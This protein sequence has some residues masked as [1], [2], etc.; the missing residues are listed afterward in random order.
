VERKILH[1]REFPKPRI[2]ITYDTT[3]SIKVRVHL[4]LEGGLIHVAGTDSN[5]ESNG[6]LLGMS[7]DV[8]PNRDGRIDTTTLLKESANSTARALGS[9]EDNINVLGGDDVGVVLEH[10]RETMGEVE[11]LALGNE[12]CNGRPCLRLGG[13]GQKVHDDST[14]ADGL[15]DRE[16]GLAGDPTIFHGLPPALAILADT[17]NDIKTIV[18]GIQ[19]LAVSLRTVTNEGKTIVLEV[20]L[21]LGEGPV[22]AL[23]DGF[24]CASKVKGLD[25]TST[26]D[27]W[28]GSFVF[29][30]FFGNDS[31]VLVHVEQP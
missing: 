24:F 26:L 5:T 13:I 2:K 8:L 6:L 25:T 3:L 27:N 11:G 18:T 15:F 14:L 4:L 7:S 9:D 12:R 29:L 21:E 19:T 30:F 10:D 16:K 22:T 23:V 31:L 1:V 20:V 28:L 17:N